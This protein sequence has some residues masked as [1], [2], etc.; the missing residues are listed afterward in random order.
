MRLIFPLPGTFYSI[1]RKA[2]P[3][4]NFADLQIMKVAFFSNLGRLGA[5]VK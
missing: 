3:A 1:A 2:L 5:G 4:I